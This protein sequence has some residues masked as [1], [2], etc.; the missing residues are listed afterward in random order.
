M[1][2]LL[3]TTMV[4][5]RTPARWIDARG[6]QWRC[7]GRAYPYD[8]MNDDVLRSFI[9]ALWE[10]VNA[11]SNGDKVRNRGVIFFFW[12]TRTDKAIACPPLI[13]GKHVLVSAKKW[14]IPWQIG[15]AIKAHASGGYHVP[16]K[17]RR[18]EP[19]F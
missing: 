2:C 11:T 18:K 4:H 5:V 9:L 8:E 7:G 3:A 13:R 14:S 10:K 19:W 6:N 17:L 1:G 16:N 15:V 12:F